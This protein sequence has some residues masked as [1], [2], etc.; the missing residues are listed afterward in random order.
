MLRHW[1]EGSH[2]RPYS[3][4]ATVSYIG[5]PRKMHSYS[6]TGVIMIVGT[7]MTVTNGGVDCKTELM[8]GIGC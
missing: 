7:V 8:G 4:T 1:C 5:S 6:W 2:L 3:S